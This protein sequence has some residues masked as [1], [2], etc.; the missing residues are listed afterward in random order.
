MSFI[1]KLHIAIICE[2]EN[3]NL[4]YCFAM[5]VQN[6]RMK[7][8]IYDYCLLLITHYQEYL[9]LSSSICFAS[10]YLPHLFF[11]SS[12]FFVQLTLG[13]CS[14]HRCRRLRRGLLSYDSN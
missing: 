14:M 11:S 7:Q 4:G 12:S 1:F 10:F 2:N 5:R 3:V 8:Q 13:M 9:M 6:E